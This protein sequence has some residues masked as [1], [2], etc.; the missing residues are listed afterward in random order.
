ML[1]VI[2][3][4]YNNIIHMIES[5]IEYMIPYHIVIDIDYDKNRVYITI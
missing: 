2:A 3:K 1:V 4:L 5:Y